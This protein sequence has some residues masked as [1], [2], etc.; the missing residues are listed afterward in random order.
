MS[1]RL[2]K[3]RSRYHE[4]QQHAGSDSQRASPFVRGTA[5]TLGVKESVVRSVVAV[6]L[7][8]TSSAATSDPL[9]L[10]TKSCADYMKTIA[11][12]SEKSP[13]TAS[14]VLSFVYGF[15]SGR[16]NSTALN[17]AEFKSFSGA[18]QQYCVANPDKSVLQAVESIK[19]QLTK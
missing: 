5:W 19:T 14:V 7:S 6:L 11:E 13:A 1:K 2:A 8:L 17:P 10:A 16:A 9:D 12:L 18:V 3:R 4:T 15:S